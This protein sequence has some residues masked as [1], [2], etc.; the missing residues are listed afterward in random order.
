MLLGLPAPSWA[1]PGTPTHVTSTT[2]VAGVEAVPMLDASWN[3]VRR[4]S[5][6]L[7]VTGQNVTGADS[8][9][10]A[11]ATVRARRG[12]T[13]PWCIRRDFSYDPVPTGSAGR[14]SITPVIVHADGTRDRQG[15]LTDDYW[16]DPGVADSISG[17]WKATLIN[18]AP[19]R[20]G[21]RVRFVVRIHLDDTVNGLSESI[22]VRA[23]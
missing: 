3:Q 10:V 11:R 17:Y 7:D 12:S 16:A 5:A 19:T 15:G 23:C 22:T 9:V 8:V 13:T 14:I 4:H 21:D 2:T 18:A 20:A 1:T 6:H